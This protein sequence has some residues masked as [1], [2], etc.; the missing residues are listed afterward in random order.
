M[1]MKE[2]SRVWDK[3]LINNN[4]LDYYNNID[5]EGEIMVPFINFSPFD[6]IIHK[7]DKIAQG[8]ISNFITVDDD[9]ASGERIGGFGST[10]K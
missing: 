4:N 5:N 7:D 8:I 6:V 10:G 3:K 2:T 1:K 9:E